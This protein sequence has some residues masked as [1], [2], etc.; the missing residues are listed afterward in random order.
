MTLGTLKMDHMD[1]ALDYQEILKRHILEDAIELGCNRK[2]P[3]DSDSR[4]AHEMLR[5][6]LLLSGLTH[7]RGG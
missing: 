3:I 7:W 5:V 6:I 4:A 2:A 1:T